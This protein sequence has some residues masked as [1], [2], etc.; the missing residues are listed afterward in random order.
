MKTETSTNVSSSAL[1]YQLSSSQEQ[2]EN[3]TICIVMK[4][5]PLD[6]LQ[7]L[8]DGAIAGAVAGSVV[9]AVLYPIDTIKTRLQAAAHGGGNV[10]VK[11]LY[12]GL[13]GNLVG[14]LPASAAFVGV[15]EP[16]KQQ[17]LKTLP[18]NF[19]A[20]AHLSAG[21]IA[22][23]ASSIVR[24]PTEVVKQRMQT[25]QFATAPKAVKMIVSKEGFRGLYAGYGSFLLRD[26]PFD[27]IQ[28]CL[29]EQIR[30]GYKLAARRELNDPETALIGAL[31]GAVT[32]AMTTPLDVIKTRLMI[33]GMGP[34]VLWI[35]IGG[36]IFFG[37]LEKT[38]QDMEEHSWT[39]WLLKEA[40]GVR[41]LFLLHWPG[42][43]LV[44][45]LCV[46]DVGSA[47]RK[48][49][50]VYVGG[51]AKT[52]DVQ[53]D[54]LCYWDVI[55][56]AKAL[57]PYDSVNGLFYLTPGM[58]MQ[59][60]LRKVDDDCAVR[61]MAESLVKYRTIDLFVQHQQ[62]VP[63]I[64]PELEVDTQKHFQPLLTH[65]EGLDN[66]SEGLENLTNNSNSSGS[67]DSED[68]LYRL[69][70]GLESEDELGN[71]NDEFVD[72]ES[73]ELEDESRAGEE[74]ECGGDISDTSDEEY[75]LVRDRVKACTSKLLK[76]AKK[77]QREAVEGKLLGQQA[78]DDDL[79]TP[80]LSEDEGE[81]FRRSNRSMLV[82]RD[83]LPEMIF[84]RLWLSMP[85][86]KV[87]T[88]D[89]FSWHSLKGS[90]IVKK[91]VNQH[92]CE[93]N[94]KKNRQLTTMWATKEMLEVFKVRPYWPAEEIK[95]TIKRA[96]KAMVT[97]NIAYKAKYKA[98][99]LLHGSMQDHYNKVY[100][101]IAAMKANNP[102]TVL[103]LVVDVSLHNNLPTFQR[104]FNCFD[105]LSKG[106]KEGCRR[107]ICVDGAFLKT[108]L[109]GQLLPVVGRDP[110][111]QMFLICWAVVEGEN[112]LSWEWFFIHLQSCLELRDG[113]CYMLPKA[114]H[115]HCARHVYAHW[116]KLG[117]RGDEMKLAF[118]S[119]AKAY[120]MSDFNEALE[121]LE[122]SNPAAALA[123]GGY[124]PKNFCRAFMNPSIKCDA[125]TNNMAE[126]F[127]GY[128]INARTQH[129]LYMMEE[130]RGA[131]MKR[132]CTKK[133]QME[134][135]TSLICPMIQAMLDKEKD[136]A[137]YC[138]VIPSI[139]D[140]FNVSHN[141][142]SLVV[143]LADSSCTCKKWDL[144]GVPCWHAI[145]C[146]YFLKREAEEY[147]NE[148]YKREV[149]LRCYANPVPVCEGE[150]HWPRVEQN[151]DPPP[152]KIGPG[153]PRRNMIKD[154]FEN[155]K[156]PGTL[157]RHGMEMTCK[158]CN[159][160]GHNKRGC[161]H[162]G[163]A[164]PQE[165]PTKK[166]REEGGL[167]WVLLGVEE[168]LVQAE[169]LLL[170]E[171][172]RGRGRGRNQVPIGVGVYFTPDG[173]PMS[174]V[175]FW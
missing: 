133:Q 69:D 12:S 163:I 10:L 32:G 46:A 170:G 66:I 134:K 84:G 128:I 155:P 174:S 71:V 68:S 34:R 72:E 75:H 61:A 7:S 120:N 172:E 56:L 156:K 33:Q 22:G 65:T 13:S 97:R 152:I 113:P 45:L 141:L 101:Y 130:I 74:D 78:N 143:N 2:V 160:K 110:N 115:R 127:N 9:E 77:L 17:L 114:E 20:L 142:Y 43:S 108:F 154:P 49:G 44:S 145:A 151:L 150:R 164:V 73:Y 27:A 83:L 54:E 29:Y 24:V 87:E 81:G 131:L 31:A 165:P 158:L 47:D 48:G 166:A 129:L 157:R 138:D 116:Q 132:V 168:V 99:K 104:L 173:T 126:T 95:E 40:S 159:R 137:C 111:D 59:G 149:Y 80:P 37:V 118:W 135:G 90:F 14:V 18:E 167:E 147:V 89:T 146:I 107:I 23:A 121:K 144:M 148:C 30:L 123:F 139:E 5:N 15:Y 51:E 124:T 64:L 38:K 171:E 103:D 28:F 16:L 102:G 55:N 53:V 1:K 117:F 82:A 153:R 6:I 162:K 119:I 76:C 106:W 100:K 58:G 3:S 105:G 86:Y 41:V 92:R 57:G 125:I 91:V 50:I 169:V 63:E 109:G 79:N 21:A 60:G 67:D 4:E 112:N 11:G 161:P 26:L 96:Y 52:L 62:T 36:S 88:W 19:S 94:M 42:C 70:G 39:A 175:C 35:G 140:I 98:H 93:R 8:Y 136:K 25:G 122:E 85:F